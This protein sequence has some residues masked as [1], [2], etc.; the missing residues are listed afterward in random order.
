MTRPGQYLPY[1]IDWMERDAYSP[2]ELRSTYRDVIAHMKRA[3]RNGVRF[4]LEDELPSV[5]PDKKKSYVAGA[6]LR[7]PYPITIIEYGFEYDD[8]YGACYYNVIIVED[9]GTYVKVRPY[10]FVGGT[11]VTISPFEANFGYDEHQMPN[12]VECWS[13]TLLDRRVQRGPETKEELVKAAA[14]ILETANSIFARLCVLLD[15]HEV[16]TTDVPPDAKENRVR[17]IKGQAPLYTYKT[18]VIGAPKKRQAV[19][20]GGTHASPRSHLRRGYYRTS[21]NGVRHWVQA[22]MVMGETP[23]FVHK[24]YKVEQQGEVQ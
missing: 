7:P 10:A 4:A 9:F 17:R 15:N 19:R 13:P 14:N 11:G 5:S 6:D 2:P 1:F 21:R 8:F 3:N 22:C 18:L 24:D 23:G 20:G 12:K 16:E